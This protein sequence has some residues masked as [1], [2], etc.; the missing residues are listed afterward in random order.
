MDVASATNVADLN[1]TRLG[2]LGEFKL[3]ASHEWKSIYFQEPENKQRFV[4]IL[5]I[6]ALL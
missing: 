3:T 6:W 2:L 1:E 4:A 5:K